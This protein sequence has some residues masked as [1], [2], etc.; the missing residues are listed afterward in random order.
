MRKA[1]VL[2]RWGTSL[3]CLVRL[4]APKV[5]CFLNGVFFV[6]ATRKGKFSDYFRM[7]SWLVVRGNDIQRG[8]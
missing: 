5:I 4:E 2:V 8:S 3:G 7:K 6:L 1:A